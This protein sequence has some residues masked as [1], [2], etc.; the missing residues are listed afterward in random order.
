MLT[1]QPGCSNAAR[2]E[3]YTAHAKGVQSTSQHV[4]VRYNLANMLRTICFICSNVKYFL[5]FFS[6][7]FSHLPHGTCLLSGPNKY[8]ALDEFY[9]QFCALLPRNATLRCQP[10]RKDW[11]WHAGI[12][13]SSLLPPKRHTGT[14]SLPW[15]L[16]IAIWDQGPNCQYELVLV[17][18]PLLKES[19]SVCFP[20]LTYMLK[21]SRSVNPTSRSSQDSWLKGSAQSFGCSN[22]NAEPAV[23]VQWLSTQSQHQHHQ[24]LMVAQHLAMHI[25]KQW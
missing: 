18:S 9:H 13:P 5:T 10:C 1:M 12:S 2:H 7:S 6:K 22:R 19:F 23:V 8:S 4:P 25:S 15:Q 16:H 14:L 21:F 24:A 17:H 11:T 20:P 3:A